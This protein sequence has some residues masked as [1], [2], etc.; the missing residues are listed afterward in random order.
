[1]E[2][3]AQAELRGVRIE[4]QWIPRNWNEET[5]NFSN[6]DTQGFDPQKEIQLN[7]MA[8]AHAT[9]NSRAAVPERDGRGRPKNDGGA[10][11]GNRQEEEDILKNREK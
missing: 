6:L 11:K 5:D 3:A 4:A 8:R 10:G 7:V 1:M 9:P 2:L